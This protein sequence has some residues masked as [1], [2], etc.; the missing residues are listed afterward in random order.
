MRQGI[1]MQTRKELTAA[2]RT[3][4]KAG[5]RGEKTRILDEFVKTTGYH[6][7]HALRL[8]SNEPTPRPRVEPER[9]YGVAVR[10]ALTLVWEAGD[11]MCGKRLKAALP[12]LV[13][14]LEGHGHLMLD[15]AVRQRLLAVS[16]ATIDR[17]LE[18]VRV[19]AG[20]KRT[21]RKTPN[22]IQ[23][24]VPV[25]T[26]QDADKLVPGYFECDFVV[27]NG[28]TTPGT[29]VHT[30]TMTDVSSG[31]TECVALV[32]RQQA[33]VVESLALIRP[34]LPVALLGF[35]S[36]NDSAFMNDT[37]FDYCK[38]EGLMQT[39]SRP[40]K[41]NDQA[42]VEQK[43]G[44]VV[45]HFAGYARLEG[46]DATRVLSRLYQSVRLYVNYF[47]PSFKLKEKRREGAKVKKLYYPPA[48]PC[49]RLLRSEHVSDQAKRRLCD[50]REQLDPVELLHNIRAAQ[51]ALRAVP[52]EEP[53]KNLEEFLDQLQHLWRAGEASPIHREAPKPQRSWPT[54]SDPFEATW[55]KIVAW[56][57]DQP[58]VAPKDLLRR[59]QGEHPGRFSSGQLRTLQR[60]V[61]EWRHAK[62]REL[63]LASCAFTD[64]V[65]ARR[66]DH[67]PVAQA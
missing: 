48:T 21:R 7:K 22:A 62:A 31:W 67:G 30:L 5:S 1:S 44:A 26:H 36:D 61:K 29:C 17:L 38:A 66:N 24:Q 47:Q 19:Q 20:R 10:E 43:N 11:R 2:L 8:M 12:S 57:N 28:G 49:D 55:P 42:W 33:L 16:P 60:R 34:Y 9:I 46:L 6:R 63:V 23:R 65:A 35:D 54:R 32:A 52:N 18:P 58:D 59:L 14:S 50:S 51:T 4:Y 45:R 37:L 3:R 15:C 41:K 27:H 64:L 40:Y 25:R 53:K 56:L 39:R 13:A